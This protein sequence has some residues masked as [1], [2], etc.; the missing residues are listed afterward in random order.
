MTS[1]SLHA[2]IL[3]AGRGSR[4]DGLNQPKT[5]LDIG[6]K[7]LLS[8]HV[9]TLATL[10]VGRIDIVVGFEAPMV[11]SGLLPHAGKVALRVIPVEWEG[12]D[13]LC[14][15]VAADIATSPADTLI[16]MDGDVLYTPEILKRLIAARAPNAVLVDRNGDDGEEPVKVC[17][18]GGRIVDFGKRPNRPGDWRGESVGFFKLGRD[19]ARAPRHRRPQAS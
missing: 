18:S 15:L 16:L 2:V 9:E 19:A 5:L 11:L 1:S 12:R 13:S 4:L 7:T 17:V 14:S 10:G 8:R 6:G 3:A